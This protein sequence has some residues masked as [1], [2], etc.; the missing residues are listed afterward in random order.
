[1]QPI[2]RLRRE[3]RLI[4]RMISLL[5][6]ELQ[7]SKRPL[8]IDTYFVAIIIDFFKTSVDRIHHGKEENIL[9]NARTKKDISEKH[10]TKSKLLRDDKIEQAIARA[11]II[12]NLQYSQEYRTNIKEIYGRLHQLIRLDPTYIKMVDTKFFFQKWTILPPMNVMPLFSNFLTVIKT[13]F[14]NTTNPS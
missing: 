14:M 12:A 8:K 6:M 3:H 2:G 13:C 7:N 9:F 1:M 11:L 4:E 10:K 5:E